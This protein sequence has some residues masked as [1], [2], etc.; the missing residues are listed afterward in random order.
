MYYLCTIPWPSPNK[1]DTHTLTHTFTLWHVYQWCAMVR[2]FI[3][4]CS[5]ALFIYCCVLLCSAPFTTTSVEGFLTTI[6]NIWHEFDC[7]VFYYLH[8]CVCV[9][10]THQHKGIIHRIIEVSWISNCKS[11]FSDF[12]KLFRKVS[13]SQSQSQSIERKK[14]L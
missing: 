14:N 13:K 6:P 11:L 4:K 7:C 9:R 10:V 3:F 1:I 2:G 5:C 8:G 12:S